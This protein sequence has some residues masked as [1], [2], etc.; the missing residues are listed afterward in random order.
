MKFISFTI[1][2]SAKEDLDLPQKIICSACKE[3]LYEG[4]LLKS[5]QDVIKKFESKC[6]KCKKEL[7]F[8]MEYVDI[9]T[10]KT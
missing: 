10:S 7:K 5:P 8:K 1:A 2:Y 3:V 4:E 9:S 6:P